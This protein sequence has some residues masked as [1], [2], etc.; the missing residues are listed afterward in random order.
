MKIQA[1]R[2]YVVG[3]GFIALVGCATYK[4]GV[5]DIRPVTDYTTRTTVDSVTVAADAYD[6]PDK[7][8]AGFYVDVTSKGYYPV[9]LIIGND[10][11]ERILVPR[12]S[13]QLVDQNG[14]TIRTTRSANMFDEFEISKMTY[15]MLGGI[16]SYMSAEDANKKMESDWRDKEIVEQL[17][18]SP[19]TK[20]NGF[21]YFKIPSGTPKGFTLKLQ[22]EGLES[23]KKRDIAVVL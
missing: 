22:V 3:I 2:W 19:A 21:V 11:G 17:I 9:N 23:R 7:A 8:K 6:S 16:F 13:I 18:L 20:G 15:A 1:L 14:N 10:S 4:R 5:V 12:E